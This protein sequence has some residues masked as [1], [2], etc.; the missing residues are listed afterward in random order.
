MARRDGET[1]RFDFFLPALLARKF[2]DAQAIKASGGNAGLCWAC[3]VQ[4]QLP[5]RIRIGKSVVMLNHDTQLF[6]HH[7]D[8]GR[9]YDFS[10][11]MAAVTVHPTNPNVWGLKNLS[12][13]NWF[14]TVTSGSVKDVQPQQSVALAIG[15]KIQ[16]GKTEGEIRL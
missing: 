1:S 8:D 13:D 12:E 3:A 15:T 5:P 16:F 9:L 6:P 11:P 4:L 7:V 10:A 2:Y 14:I